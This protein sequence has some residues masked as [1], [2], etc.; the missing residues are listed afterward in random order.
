M[1]Q[2]SVSS[3]V[4]QALPVSVGFNGTGAPA[5]QIL[6]MGTALCFCWGLRGQPG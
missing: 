1:V 4:T 5:A 3:W 2:G 6:A